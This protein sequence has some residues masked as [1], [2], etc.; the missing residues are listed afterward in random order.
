MVPYLKV[1][2]KPVL[3]C[4]AQRFHLL[5]GNQ[6]E[7]TEPRADP[8]L[9]EAGNTVSALLFL[10]SHLTALFFWGGGEITD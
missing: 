2:E 7:P 3:T 8:T 6:Q 4:D 10:I 9:H 5:P 1:K